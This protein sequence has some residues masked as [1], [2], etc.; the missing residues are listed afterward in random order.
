MYTFFVY[1]NNNNF[2]H[3]SNISRVANVIWRNA[4]ISRAEISRHLDLYRS[5]VSNIITLLLEKNFVMETSIGNS[6]K[7]GG[8]RPVAL[9]LNAIFGCVIGIEIQPEKFHIIVIDINNEVI[10]HKDGENPKLPFK[11]TFDFIL[12][13]VI[14]FI[15]NLKIPIL[16]ICVGL[17]GIINNKKNEIISSQPLQLANFNFS[18]EIATKYNIPV[19][20]ENDARCCAW[21]DTTINRR[22][23]VKNFI[24]LTSVYHEKQIEK[25]SHIGI[26]IGIAL[27][28]QGKL[29]LGN[30]FTAGEYT[31]LSWR[32]K[33]PYQTGLPKEITEHLQDN[34]EA[35]TTWLKDFFST[36]TPITSVFAPEKIFIHGNLVQKKSKILET[37][38]ESVPQFEAILKKTECSLEFAAPDSFAIARGAACYYLNKLFSIP[39]IE[40]YEGN[41]AVPNW[42][43]AFQT[44]ENA[45]KSSDYFLKN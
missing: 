3:N 30:N 5:T 14:P 8:R 13:Q 39:N 43:T 42:D 41:F 25:E 11:E 44:V 20:V 36:L 34:N 32:P 10:M 6:T 35:F 31:S 37:I 4:L 38:Q 19:L 27:V 7:L 45:Q 1:I 18:K 16:A 29:H 24:S 22:E 28:S 33:I 23:S 2:Q 21:L 12:Q 40:D 17:P 26:G 9:A 15:Q